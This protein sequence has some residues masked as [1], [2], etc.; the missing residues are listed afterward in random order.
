MEIYNDW[1]VSKMSRSELTELSTEERTERK[2]LQNCIN[3]KKYRENH[4]EYNKEKQKKYYEEHK[5][6][7]VE[8][9]KEYSK[10]YYQTPIGKKN[11]TL[12]S[13]KSM[14]LQETKE[15]LDI[16]YD[17]W[18]HQEL[19]YSCDVKLTRNGDN[20]QDQACMDHDHTTHKFRQICCRSCNCQDNWMTYWC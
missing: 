5:E 20:S 1:L 19:C 12:S 15:E 14:G 3:G 6:E 11:K 8:K 16:I 9:Q 4:P 18:L 7:V 10:K 13:W 17:M 2:R